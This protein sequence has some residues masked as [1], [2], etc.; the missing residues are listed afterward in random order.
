M[1]PEP[2]LTLTIPSVHDGL[3][4]DCRI[5]HPASLRAISRAP[6]WKKH[7]AVLAHPYA[8]LGGSYDDPVIEIVGAKILE[9]GYLLAT[10]NFRG[11]GHSA[12]KTSWTSR[13]ERCDFQ[14]VIA[15][16]AYYM[17]HLDP[18][19][20]AAESTVEEAEEPSRTTL[21]AVIDEN[22]IDKPERTATA[23]NNSR[24]VRLAP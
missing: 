1:L 11:A 14:S 18:F 21:D 22:A 16:L 17:H 7:A 13:A 10:F 5:Y 6:P 24:A 19:K 8:P 9:E 4:L 3:S 2:A 20:N 15:F 12:G 23:G